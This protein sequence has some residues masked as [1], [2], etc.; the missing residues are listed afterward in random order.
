MPTVVLTGQA[1]ANRLLQEQAA[2]RIMQAYHK[3]LLELGFEWDGADGYLAPN[4]ASAVEE[5]HRFWDELTGG[6][7]VT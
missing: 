3:K 7:N 5:A 4:N 1:W 2:A 6:N